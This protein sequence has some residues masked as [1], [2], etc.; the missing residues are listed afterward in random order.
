MRVAEIG[1]SD[2]FARRTRSAGAAELNTIL[3][4][5]PPGVL[6][7]AGGFP[8]P[9]TFPTEVL[10]EIVMR[11]VRDDAGIALQYAAARAS[12]AS[13]STW[14]TARSGSRAAAR[15]SRS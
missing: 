8:N 2:S 10:D 6:S 14:S 1:W 15:S 13:A 5:A 7:L 11:L 3:A 9:A 12:R 4:G